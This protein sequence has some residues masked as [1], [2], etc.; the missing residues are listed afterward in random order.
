MNQLPLEVYQHIIS[1]A[2]YLS[3]NRKPEPWDRSSQ[4]TLHSPWV[5]ARL[6]MKE[7]TGTDPF[8]VWR[9]RSECWRGRRGRLRVDLYMQ[10]EDLPKIVELLL[11]TGL[12]RDGIITLASTVLQKE[13]LNPIGSRKAFK[14]LLDRARDMSDQGLLDEIFAVS[15]RRWGRPWSLRSWLRRTADESVMFDID[16]YISHSQHNADLALHVLN[17]YGSGGDSP[18]GLEAGREIETEDDAPEL[19]LS[20]DTLFYAFAEGSLPLLLKVADCLA[21]QRSDVVTFFALNIERVRLWRKWSAHWETAWWGS[22]DVVE[23]I[24]SGIWNIPLDRLRTVNDFYRVHQHLKDMEWFFHNC[25]LAEE[26]ACI[27]HAKDKRGAE[28]ALLDHSPR[29][30]LKGAFGAEYRDA[31]YD[32]ADYD[33]QEWTLDVLIRGG[34]HPGELPLSRHNKYDLIEMVGRSCD[35]ERRDRL[36]EAFLCFVT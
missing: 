5:I 1:S 35:T 22:S 32:N 36:K 23:Y 34:F 21:M 4:V 10:H 28:K 33:L 24:G 17:A 15:V 9:V 7:Y 27:L 13:R 11:R 6:I 31:V 30:I 14:V 20:A 2:C 29:D 26:V 8:I 16:A 12:D 18:D 25:T 19:T 3:C